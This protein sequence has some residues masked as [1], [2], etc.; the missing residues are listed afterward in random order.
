MVTLITAYKSDGTCIGRCDAKC[1]NAECVNCQ[2][3]CGGANHGKGIN[4]ASE[5]TKE[6]MEKWMEDYRQKFE[7]DHFK[8]SDEVQLALF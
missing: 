1:Y 2:C 7:V 6:M 8:V 4:Q 3:I 5:N